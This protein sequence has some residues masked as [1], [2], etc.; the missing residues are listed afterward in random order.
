MSVVCR[1]FEHATNTMLVSR[2]EGVLPKE[3]ALFRT[4]PGYWV[5]IF[6]TDGMFCRLPMTQPLAFGN[7]R[8]INAIPSLACSAIAPRL[9]RDCPGFAREET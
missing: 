4:R 3:Y 9:A 7:R 2:S 8:G 1:D 5:D 6:E